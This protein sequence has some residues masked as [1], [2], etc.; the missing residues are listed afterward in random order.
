MRAKSFLDEGRSRLKVSKTS[1][2]RDTEEVNEVDGEHYELGRR[3]TDDGGEIVSNNTEAVPSL[4]QVRVVCN[5]CLFVMRPFEM[6]L[7][8]VIFPLLTFGTNNELY[9]EPSTIVSQL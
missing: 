8:V 7:V 9:F 4:P 1:L 3:V 6:W 2:S 5:M